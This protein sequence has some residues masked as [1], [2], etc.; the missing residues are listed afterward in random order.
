MTQLFEGFIGDRVPN[1]GGPGSVYVC[2]P[3]NR[4]PLDPANHVRNHSPD[5]FQWG[6]GGSGPAQLALAICV[7][8]VGEERALKVYQPF[9]MRVIASLPDEW[10]LSKERALSI[11]KEIETVN[12]TEQILGDP[13]E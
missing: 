3:P 10:E 2:E 6:Y 11:I 9:K 1:Q 7:R 8:L 12:N 4:F 5:G 13:L